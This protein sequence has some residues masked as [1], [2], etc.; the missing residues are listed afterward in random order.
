MNLYVYPKVKHRRTE[1]PGSWNDYRRYK[2]VLRKE[3][4]GRCVYCRRPDVF[5]PDAFGVDHY[6]PKKKFP[7]LATS[8]SNLFYACNACNAH[9]GDFWPEDAERELG[10]L[11]PNP[12]DCVMF[13]HLRFNGAEVEVRTNAGRCAV[14]V[15]D[16]NNAKEVE[17]RQ[18]M[19]MTVNA[20]VGEAKRIGETV[21]E[22]DNRLAGGPPRQ[23]ELRRL[24][25]QHIQELETAKKLLRDLGI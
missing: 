5:S 10:Y 13:E 4:D 16:L 15:L 8:Y 7:S 14:D 25:D 22:I 11:I 21:A 20:L 12:C 6:K 9:K 19:T 17:F 2:A 18:Y 23:K 3:F 1:S 24:R